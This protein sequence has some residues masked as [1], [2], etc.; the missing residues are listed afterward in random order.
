[1]A[2]PLLYVEQLAFSV[3]LLL[4]YDFIGIDIIG[5]AHIKHKMSGKGEKM[6]LRFPRFSK[7]LGNHK[8]S[9]KV[10][11]F[12]FLSW[13]LIAFLVLLCMRVDG[14]KGPRAKEFAMLCGSVIISTAWWTLFSFWLYKPSLIFI[15]SMA[16]YIKLH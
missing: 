6:K 11:K 9:A 2:I 3:L 16:D 15:K 10:V 12:S 8:N 13:Q 7:F 1:M 4:F 14:K 5:L